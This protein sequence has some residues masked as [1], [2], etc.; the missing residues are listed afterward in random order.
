MTLFDTLWDCILQ[1]KPITARYKG[2]TRVLCPHVL[3]YKDG[4]EHCLFYQCG[5]SSESGLGPI[6][7]SRNWRCMELDSLDKVEIKDGEWYT[8]YVK[9]SEHQTC[10]EQVVIQVTEEVEV[11]HG[12]TART[13]LPRARS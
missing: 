7:S 10:V 13:G 11:E 1:K 9:L 8:S 5:G 4:K 3:G 6:G 2:H 12:E